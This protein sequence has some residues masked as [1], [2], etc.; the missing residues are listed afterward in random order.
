[1]AELRARLHRRAE[2]ADDVIERRLVNARTEIAQWTNFDYIVVNDDLQGAF[3]DLKCILTAERKRRQRIEAG[4]GTFVEG[5][6]A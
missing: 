5:L 3:D 4:V 6:L 1:M 2:D